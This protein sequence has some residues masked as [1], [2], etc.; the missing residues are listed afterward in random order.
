MKRRF[1]S[2][3]GHRAQ[4]SRFPKSHLSEFGNLSLRLMP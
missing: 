4:D 3:S 2:G 1:A